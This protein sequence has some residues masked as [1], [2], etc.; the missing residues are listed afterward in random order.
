MVPKKDLVALAARE[1][2][3]EKAA[4][5]RKRLALAGEERDLRRLRR[6]PSMPK[7]KPLSQEERVR[8]SLTNVPTTMTPLFLLRS[9]G[10]GFNRQLKAAR[11]RIRMALLPEDMKVFEQTDPKGLRSL[12]QFYK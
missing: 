4:G 3:V 11:E 1:A 12:R 7:A 8:E 10:K 6:G 2:L 5:K 9:A